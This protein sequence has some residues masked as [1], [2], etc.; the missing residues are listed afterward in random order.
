MDKTRLSKF[1][2]FSEISPETLEIIASKCIVKD[3]Q[4]N[5]ILFYQDDPAKDFFGVIEGEV[6]LNLVYKEKV[7]TKQIVDYEKSIVSK[8][9]IQERPIV[10]DIIGPEEVFGWSSFFNSGWTATARCSEPSKIFSIS[11]SELKAVFEK[12]KALGYAFMTGLA[13]MISQRLHH[14]TDKLIE[15]WGE[16]FGTDMIETA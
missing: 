15:V 6:E 11:V 10:A 9:E 12:D 16:A 2:I 3:Y 8:Y 4:E 13:G 7:M 14:R 5:D 1:E